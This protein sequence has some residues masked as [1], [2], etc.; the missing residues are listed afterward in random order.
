MKRIPSLIYRAVAL[1]GLWLAL[2]LY[3]IIPHT[4]P[5]ISSK[6]IMIINIALIAWVTLNNLWGLACEGKRLDE[7]CIGDGLIPE[8]GLQKESTQKKIA[9]YP[10]VPKKY[11]NKEPEGVILGTYKNQYVRIP[12]QEIY[13]YCVIGGSRSGKTSTV[14][15]DTLL[16]NF[17]TKKNDF[18]TYAIDIKGELHIKSSYS[19]SPDIMVVNPTDQTTAGWDVYYRLRDNP[20]DDLI[21]EV[22]QEVA[23]ALIISTS[24]SDSFF[25]N[26]AQDM[27]VGMLLYFY[28]QGENFID[29]VNK[30]LES[31][32][33]SLIGEIIKSSE[34]SDLHY[35]Y[36]A[37]FDGKDAESVEDCMVELTTNLSVFGS[38]SD[39]KY[40]FRDNPIKASPFTFKENKSVFLA[41][42]EH[43][44]ESYK[45]ILRLCTVQTLKEMERRPDASGKEVKNKPM[46][47]LIDEF[48]RLGRMEGIFNALATLAS[49]KIS[50]ILAFQS[51]AQCEV[52]YSKEETRVLMDNCRV[53][54]ICEV[55][56]PQSAKA[57][58]DWCG[59]YREKKE[60][61]SAGKNRH[62][63]YT[64]EDK[65]IVQPN[66]LITLVNQEEVILIISGV[67]YLRPKKCYYFKDSQISKLAQKVRNHNTTDIPLI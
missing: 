54:V 14:L 49:K 13:H 41:I 28:Q 22:M 15:L 44:L 48:A 23:S 62:K 1:T 24:K 47:I 37:K 34:P 16:A 8:T 10:K 59:K 19:H 27:F 58:Q 2:P 56:D 11:L 35:K 33:K 46:I 30:I 31:E 32:I 29:S 17:A 66:D 25:V 43:M 3:L 61:L 38:K 53:K 26:N 18:L 50:V 67:G 6:Q 51:L 52:I 7:M 12:T 4:I 64:Y 40:C 45:A 39:I 42:P 60:T 55:S 63:T 21:I 20:S 57:V 36:L 65:D 9:T 5:S